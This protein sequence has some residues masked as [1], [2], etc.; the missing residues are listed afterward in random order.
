VPVKQKKSYRLTVESVRRVQAESE[1]LGVTDTAI[2]E[3][4]I[5]KSLPALIT[6]S[7]APTKEETGS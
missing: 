5:R 2:V 3:M 6:T 1:R 4:A 7:T